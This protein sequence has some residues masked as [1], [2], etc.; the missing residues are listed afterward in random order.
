[1]S[2]PVTEANFGQALEAARQ[3]A[4]NN[5]A[6]AAGA[7]Q[8]ADAHVL[9][10]E[11]NDINQEVAREILRL[12]GLSVSLA[13]TGQ[14]ALDCLER[15]S[16]DLVLMDLQMPEM[17]G[18][19]ATRRARALG[20]RLPI[21]AMTANARREDRE[22]CLAAGM[23]DYLSKPINP[24]VLS[25]L[26]RRYLQPGSL[27][28]PESQDE[29]TEFP[30]LSG[31]NCQ[32]GLRRLGG[33]RRLYRSLLLQFARRQQSVCDRLE[34]VQGDELRALV[35]T[36][37]GAAGNLGAEVLAARCR[38]WEEGR[39]NLT[40]L[41]SELKRVI[42]ASMGLEELEFNGRRSGKILDQVKVAGLLAR[43]RRLLDQDLGEA[44][45][46]LEEVVQEMEGTALSPQAVQL[47]VWMEE[48]E[49]DQARALVEALL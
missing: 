48:F 5:Q 39:F 43:L 8:F 46:T 17:D 42:Q 40:E 30:E 16:F 3:R 19:E 44:F 18:L 41:Q 24:E 23:D 22:L 2:K 13:A 29:Q 26:L 37:K 32:A 7:K 49:V 36:I 12:F 11:D 38:A 25:Q 15:E 33:N 21:L 4:L 31:I 45:V 6:L 35:H 34:Q 1:L 28:V 9:L 14:E 10:V 47:K 20:H 27:P